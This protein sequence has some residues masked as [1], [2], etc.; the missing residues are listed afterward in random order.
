MKILS[1][2]TET[3]EHRKQKKNKHYRISTT[4]NVQKAYSTFLVRATYLHFGVPP[5]ITER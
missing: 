2:M 3:G 1:R 4:P 5:L